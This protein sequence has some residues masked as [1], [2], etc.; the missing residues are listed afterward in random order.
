MAFISY[1]FHW[2]EEE[3]LSMDHNMR[4][5]WCSEISQINASLNP[6]E[7]KSREKSILD[8]TPTNMVRM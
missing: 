7:G 1:Y 5:R 2:S 8:M 3:V 4:R 6:S